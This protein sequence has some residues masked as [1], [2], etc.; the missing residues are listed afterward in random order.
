MSRHAIA[1]LLCAAVAEAIACSSGGGG[2]EVAEGGIGGTGI[3][4]GAV[5][6]F[7]SFF[8]TGTEW[9]L[10]ATGS[11]EIDGE[12]QGAMGSFDEDDLELG[13]Y[14]R[15][16]GDRD[17]GSGTGTAESVRYDEAILGAVEGSP[18]QVS[19]DRRTFTVLGQM[20]TM[21]D[22]QTVFAGTSFL[23]LDQ[24]D[25]VEVSGPVDSA[26]GIRATRIEKRG[27]LMLGTTQVEVKGRVSD[28]GPGVFDLGSAEVSFDCASFTDCSALPGA[29]V[30]DGQDVEVEA[31]QTGAGA[32]PELEASLVRP[33]E[34]IAD[35]LADAQNVELEGV[36]DDFVSL[37]SFT[38]NGLAVDASSAELEPDAPSRFGDG[39]YVEVSGDAAGGV[40]VAERL[41]LEEGEALVLAQIGS[42]G[43]DR[44]GSG[45]IVL[46][47][48]GVMGQPGYQ[49]LVVEVSAATRIEDHVGGDPDLNLGELMVGDFLVVH[50][51][52]LPG[53]RLRA[54]GIDREDVGELKLRGPVE[55]VDTDSGDG[56][57]GYR[58]LGIFVELVQG[59]TSVPGGDVDA[60]LA[61]VVPGDI[62]QAKD[63]EDGSET[64]FDIADEVERE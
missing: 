16:D 21:V 33:F 34:P 56:V 55:S 47:A 14:L 26:G 11:V 38:V 42:D 18:A 7:G 3:S 49:E 23:D 40:L 15:V 32:T 2:S 29:A 36:I 59:T 17:G 44:V 39:V 20:V 5:T 37:S 6:A 8:V 12:T 58:V 35:A 30:A 63:D 51:I 10:G 24:D 31:V 46:L 57:V 53:G 4:S 48:E 43:L 41:E 52:A 27:S 45:E 50:G 61:T 1:L 60:F 9:S 28:L 62:L 19:S 54:S 13:M 64:T 25:V 22:G